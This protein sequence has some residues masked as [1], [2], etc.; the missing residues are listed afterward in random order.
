MALRTA[1]SSLAREYCRVRSSPVLGRK[2][3]LGVRY[4]KEMGKGRGM[5]WSRRRR[6]GDKGILVSIRDT[7]K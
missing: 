4:V 7:R 2:D 1:A 6:V 5:R 3:R